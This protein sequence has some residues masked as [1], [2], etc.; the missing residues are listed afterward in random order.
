VVNKICKIIEYRK[1]KHYRNEFYILS[2]QKINISKALPTTIAN[3]ELEFIKAIKKAKGFSVET[4]QH[5]IKWINH[6]N[7][8]I[9]NLSRVEYKNGA[10]VRKGAF[11]ECILVEDNGV[12]KIDKYLIDNRYHNDFIREKRILIELSTS[13][14]AVQIDPDI[15]IE[16]NNFYRMEFIEYD[17][18][19]FILV[20]T[21]YKDELL[22]NYFVL[23]L[24]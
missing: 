7:R 21:D 6:I 18:Q 13:N 12:Y 2:N 24:D 3:K 10:F 15:Y 11:G 5:F 1:T 9:Y 23:Q 14:I 8:N 19:D 20:N 16:H 17:L 4:D 22:K